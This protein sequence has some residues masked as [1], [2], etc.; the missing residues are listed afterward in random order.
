MSRSRFAR[1]AALAVRWVLLSCGCQVTLHGNAPVPTWCP[2]CVVPVT[3]DA[4]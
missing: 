2:D 3:R 4:G 1:C